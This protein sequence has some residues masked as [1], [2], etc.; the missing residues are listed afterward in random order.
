MTERVSFDAR[1][2]A[3]IGFPASPEDLR[4]DHIWDFYQRAEQERVEGGYGEDELRHLFDYVSGVGTMRSNKA[5]FMRN[6]CEPLCNAVK[7]IFGTGASPRIL[8][9]CCGT[10]TQALMFAILGGRVVGLDYNEGQLATLRTRKAYY[11]GRTGLDLDIEIV[12]ASV[13]DF[14]FASLG[15]F[16]A[17]YS[18]IGVGRLLS[19]E[20]IFDRIGATLR[21]SGVLA[22]KNGNPQCLWLRVFGRAQKDSPRRRYI[23]AAR[24][25]GY[26]VERAA[27][28]T[29]LPKKLW[30]IPAAARGFDAVFGGVLP[31]QMSLAYT[32][33]KPGLQG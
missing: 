2:A 23:A 18:H 4:P 5:Y 29:A 33:R 11:E 1:G 22:L 20:E 17:A 9:V 7:D 3:A 6:Y 12:Q 31:L 28:P 21:P 26:A 25:R 16:D 32:F 8:D 27:G 13:F 15:T 24:E 14:D 10:G 30:A 19:A